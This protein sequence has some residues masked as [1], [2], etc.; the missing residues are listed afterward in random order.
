MINLRVSLF[1]YKHFIRRYSQL[2][3]VFYLSQGVLRKE[4]EIS[5]DSQLLLGDLNERSK[6]LKEKVQF[7]DGTLVA[8][9]AECR[10]KCCRGSYDHFTAIDYWLKK[11]SKKPLPGYGDE[12][13]TPWYVV[14]LKE[15][16]GMSAF[17]EVS[18]HGYGCPNLGDYGCK[19]EMKQRPIKCV[20]FTCRRFRNS[21][22]HEEREIYAGVIRN[23][24]K[25][26]LATFD[27]LK[28]E[29]GLPRWFGKMDLFV[30][31]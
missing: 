14:L 8:I 20:V 28:K 30:R 2:V 6:D 23:L 3:R 1:D 19:L 26:S 22:K 17:S 15:R 9:C 7:Y 27:V 21:M 18:S 4:S 31:Y 16:F 11:Y 10:G 13:G 24:L 12:L 5:K 29:R 25:V